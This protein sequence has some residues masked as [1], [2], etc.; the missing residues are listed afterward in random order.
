MV[1][2]TNVDSSIVLSVYCSDG[3]GAAS[4]STGG[5]FWCILFLALLNRLLF[6]MM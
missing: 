4:I 2:S 5:S 6:F 3:D 1:A